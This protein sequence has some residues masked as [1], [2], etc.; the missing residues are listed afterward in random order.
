MHKANLLEAH[1]IYVLF[2]TVK[3]Y[4]KISRWHTKMYSLIV[5]KLNY[6]NSQTGVVCLYFSGYGFSG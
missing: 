6:I 1:Y 4:F 3:M 2:G 5:S